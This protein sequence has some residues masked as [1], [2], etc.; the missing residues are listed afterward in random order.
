ML[1]SSG[2]TC[3]FQRNLQIS[4]SMEGE[5]E[6]WDDMDEEILEDWAGSIS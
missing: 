5:I 2:F 3:C 6:K 1:P 4:T